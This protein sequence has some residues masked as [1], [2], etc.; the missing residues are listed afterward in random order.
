M[1][2]EIIIIDITRWCGVHVHAVLAVQ[3][4][5]ASIPGRSQLRKSRGAGIEAK[6]AWARVIAYTYLLP[7]K[8]SSVNIKIV[9]EHSLTSWSC[10]HSTVKLLI[11]VYAFPERWTLYVLLCLVTAPLKWSVKDKEP[12]TCPSLDWVLTW[13]QEIQNTNCLYP[14]I[15]YCMHACNWSGF[16]ECVNWQDVYIYSSCLVN[17]SMCCVSMA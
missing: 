13:V 11:L 5:L 6:P 10:P 16:F 1:V 4:A 2:R 9:C 12:L 15:D 3:P 7:K 8:L 17:S 14:V